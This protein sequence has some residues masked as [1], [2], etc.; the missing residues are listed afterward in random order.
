MRNAVIRGL[1]IVVNYIV[2]IMEK[3]ITMANVCEEHG[4]GRVSK[5]MLL[6]QRDERKR[7]ER[8]EEGVRD[9]VELRGLYDENVMDRQ[10][11]RS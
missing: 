8:M 7:S 10:K 6:Y 4:D 2:E 5:E 3:K 11:Q 9:S 1:T